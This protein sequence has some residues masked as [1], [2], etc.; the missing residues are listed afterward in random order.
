[1]MYVLVAAL[2][3]RIKFW[4]V[5]ML[6]LIAEFLLIDTDLCKNAITMG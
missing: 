4:S 1:M 5:V 3:K 2:M 6:P